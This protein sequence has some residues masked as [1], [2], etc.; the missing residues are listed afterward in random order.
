M[1][2][3]V[4]KVNLA[5]TKA[6]AGDTTYIAAV[7]M[8]GLNYA[9]QVGQTIYTSPAVF[10]FLIDE[11][12]EYTREIVMDQVKVYHEDTSPTIVYK[13][14]RMIM[15]IVEPKKHNDRKKRKSDNPIG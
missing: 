3:K 6:I 9:I 13:T 8:T 12:D 4:L 11:D 7:E 14:Y 15:G 1:N 5:K 2:L 10:S